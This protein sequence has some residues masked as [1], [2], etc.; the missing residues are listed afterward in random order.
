MSEENDLGTLIRMLNPYIDGTAG[1]MRFGPIESGPEVG[2][3][4]IPADVSRIQIKVDNS[5]I[6]WTF[7]GELHKKSERSASHIAGRAKT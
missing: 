3:E 1:T 6:E 7:K 2:P 5:P 4:T